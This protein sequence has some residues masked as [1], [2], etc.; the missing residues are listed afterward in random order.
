M[1]EK[2]HLGDPGVDRRIIF[3]KWDVRYGLDQTGLG[4]GQVAGTCE[5]GNAVMNI[6]F[7]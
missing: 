7:P 5:C 2:D 6:R 4:Q 3:R 1:R